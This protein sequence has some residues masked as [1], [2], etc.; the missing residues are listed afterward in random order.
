MCGLLHAVVPGHRR[1]GQDHDR[2][3]KGPGWDKN[4]PDRT[5]IPPGDHLLFE[6]SFDEATWQAPPLP[7]SGKSRT[8]R[9]Q[10]IFEVPADQDTKANQVWT[11]SAL[12]GGRLHDLPLSGK[13]CFG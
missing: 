8:V 2:E 10:A 6:V 3:E 7:E 1:S 9:L 12:A 13:G 5:T 4:Y 11:G